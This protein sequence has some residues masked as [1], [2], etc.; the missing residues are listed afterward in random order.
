[1]SLTLVKNIPVGDSKP[2]AFCSMG[3]SFVLIIVERLRLM[4]WAIAIG[5]LG[6]LDED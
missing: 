2:I 6:W 1:V 5:D 4:Y 3:K